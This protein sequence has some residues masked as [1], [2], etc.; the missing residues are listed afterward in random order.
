MPVAEPE[1]FRES[2]SRGKL[3]SMLFHSWKRK[4]VTGIYY[5]R[6][7]PKSDPVQFVVNKVH[8][9]GGETGKSVEACSRANPDCEACGV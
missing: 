8:V 3:T 7:R 2:P 6:S 4:L 5:L 9:N 1:S